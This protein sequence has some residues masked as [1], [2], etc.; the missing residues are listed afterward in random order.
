[1]VGTFFILG[2]VLLGM[3][4]T[5]A[6]QSDESQHAI[7]GGGNGPVRSVMQSAHLS[8]ERK[9]PARNSPESGS[10]FRDAY[11]MPREQGWDRFTNFSRP[12]A[13]NVQVAGRKSSQYSKSL[14]PLKFEP[15]PLGSVKP[16]GWQRQQLD[17]M[18]EGLP[19]RMHEFYRMVTD[20]PWM[21][22]HTEYSP[23]NEAY[24]YYYDGVVPLAYLLE[25]ERLIS[26]VLKSTRYILD[27]QQHDDGWLGPEQ[28]TR[29]RNF[30]GR[31]PLFLGMM[32][33]AQADPGQEKE[34]IRSMHRFVDLMH[35]MLQT[36]YE[37]YVWKPG[38]LFDQQWGR[39]R[40]ADMILVLQWLYEHHPHENSDK[41]HD[42]IVW[43]Y[44]MAY[45][46][47]YYFQEGVFLKQNL[48]DH[49]NDL[50]DSLF[51][52][53]HVVN[54][55]QGLKSPAVMR[56]LTHDNHL[57]EK[58]RIGVDWTFRYHGTPSGAIY[59]DERQSSQRPFRGTELCSVV[60][61]M[62]SLNYLHQALGDGSFADRSEEA[63]FNAM[64]AMI[65]PHWWAHQ[66][67]AQTNQPASHELGRTPFWNVGPW[68]QTFGTE[69]NYP[70]CAVRF[71]TGLPK[72]IASSFVREGQ[73]HIVH[74]LLG[75]GEL[76]TT[77]HPTSSSGKA[78]KNKVHITCDTNYPF[79]HIL[80]YTVHPHAHP[81]R[82]SIRVPEWNIA[83]QAG[84]QLFH[85]GNSSNSS[86]LPLTPDAH[87]NLHTLLLPANSSPLT[88]KVWF[89]ASVRI[90][91]HESDTISIHHGA[92]LYAYDIPAEYRSRPPARYQSPGE[93]PDK[94]RDWT[95]TPAEQSSGNDTDDGSA[96]DYAWWALA[97][98]PTTARFHGYKNRY[99]KAGPGK[100]DT[101]PNPIWE[102]DAP[103]VGISVLACPIAEWDL[104][105]E[106][107][108]ICRPR[109][110][111]EV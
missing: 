105:P 5:G 103:P 3:R 48:E 51:P 61:S 83:E 63:A 40:A 7:G 73:D 55:A 10:M 50:L 85:S 11:G 78:G 25:D 95:I 2:A 41:L 26:H 32:Q 60:E 21:G 23:L 101:F 6:H 36:G 47:S 38:A 29:R 62:F 24:T 79:T 89:G 43:M 28:D 20:A 54:A 27:N 46:W 71:S 93:A 70:C 16:L 42:C 44:E 97:L 12:P 69:P 76:H 100:K 96:I 66:Y 72:Y 92:L 33:L 39:S 65:L 67:V 111:Q 1:M 57:A 104:N 106:A 59:G 53:L 90:E 77:L 31:Y 56:R 86:V 37:G 64:P 98:D 81:F 9:G 17:L 107:G 30:W 84:I 22:G 45:D 74:A 68:G 99:D 52:Y 91:H 19:G 87:T 102:S 88:I 82:F 14:L 13:Y 49:P 109:R 4:A 80:T 75:P 110:G 58:A 35:E 34:V 108:C 94:A 18:A 8:D 15:F